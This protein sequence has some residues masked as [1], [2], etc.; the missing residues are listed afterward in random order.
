VLAF[1]PL[2]LGDLFENALSDPVVL[3]QLLDR[4]KSSIGFKA[5]GP[6]GGQGSSRRPMPKS[7]VLLRV[8]SGRPAR[9]FLK[10]CLI[11]G[12]L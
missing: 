4:K 6:Q 3:T 8:V 2:R 12:L 7:W 1:N 5:Y 10:Y 11:F 9:F